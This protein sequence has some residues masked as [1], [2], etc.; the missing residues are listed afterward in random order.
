MESQRRVFM[1]I[2]TLGRR[3]TNCLNLPPMPGV[4]AL[5]RAPDLLA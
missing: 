5:L 4:F 2:G 1:L 3:P